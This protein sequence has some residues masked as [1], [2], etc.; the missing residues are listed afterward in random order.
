M[1][2][3][4]FLDLKS[5]MPL[6]EMFSTIRRNCETVSSLQ[7]EMNS[8]DKAK[9]VNVVE[10]STTSFSVLNSSS[11]EEVEYEVTEDTLGEEA[12]YY[13]NLINNV[14]HNGSENTLDD[15]NSVLPS[16][17]NS[18]Y[19]KI[20]QRI[21]A[22]YLR[23]YNEIISLLLCEGDSFSKSEYNEFYKDAIEIKSLIKTLKEIEYSNVVTKEESVTK[24]N[25]VF[26]TTESGKYYALSDVLG[27]DQSNYEGILD[28]L[29]SII[30]GTFKNVKRFDSS[31]D[32]L[33]SLAEVK[34][35]NKRILFDRLNKDTYVILAIFIKKSQRDKGYHDF[36]VHRHA[37]YRLKEED[38][39]RMI[40]DPVYLAQSE[41]VLSSLLETLS[42]TSVNKMGGM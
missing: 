20:M 16:K 19:H 11:E 22:S 42:K 26:L 3:G 33:F 27:L 6:E 21:Q 37:L 10:K 17:I 12:S 40:N 8:L 34:S 38:L 13:I 30:N 35:T 41:E 29:N 9:Q 1:K 7:R 23:D 31:N 14:I 36:L 5:D 4:D 32:K 39:K 2:H 24:N 28:L 15:L 18:R 25:I